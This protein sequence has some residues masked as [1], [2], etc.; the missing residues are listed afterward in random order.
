MRNLATLWPNRPWI[1]ASGIF[2]CLLGVVLLVLPGP[3]LLLLAVGLSLLGAEYLWARRLLR[4][5]R[6]SLERRGL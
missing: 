5:V 6:A 4:R 2:L 1:A 3:G